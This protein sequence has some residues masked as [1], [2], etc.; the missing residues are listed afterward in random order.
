MA[1]KRKELVPTLMIRTWKASTI[2]NAIKNSNDFELQQAYLDATKSESDGKNLPIP[3]IPG[4]F[5]EDRT[6][7]R[8]RLQKSIHYMEGIE[9]AL[10]ILEE[11]G[12]DLSKARFHRLD[13]W[14]EPLGEVLE[15]GKRKLPKGFAK[16]YVMQELKKENMEAVE[17]RLNTMVLDLKK[18]KHKVIDEN[19]L[20]NVRD[21]LN[22]AYGSI[23]AIRYCEPGEKLTYFCRMVKP[24]KG[25]KEK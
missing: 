4:A 19:F 13:L 12:F 9:L 2:V 1:I 23:A 20:I 21:L 5:I 7:R 18:P 8:Q 14:C 10:K 15:F 22:K 6:I 16:D 17:D 11:K 25:G 24:S 3:R